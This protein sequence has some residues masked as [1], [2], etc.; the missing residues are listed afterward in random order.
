[1]FMTARVLSAYYNFPFKVDMEGIVV[2]ERALIF[3]IVGIF[4]QTHETVILQR[5]PPQKLREEPYLLEILPVL[6]PFHTFPE[7][8]F[9]SGS[10]IHTMKIG[11]GYESPYFLCDRAPTELTQP[12]LHDLPALFCEH[13]AHVAVI[14]H[15]AL[16]SA[17][18]LENGDDSAKNGNKNFHIDIRH[19]SLPNDYGCAE[20][21]A[22]A[23]RMRQVILRYVLWKQMPE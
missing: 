22:G 18:I 20:S 23:K 3:G 14:A 7:E 17:F 21:S 12:L 9:A 10:G 19:G 16:P 11:G 13:D 15:K 2:P 5:Q 8:D 1:M 6:I 4:S